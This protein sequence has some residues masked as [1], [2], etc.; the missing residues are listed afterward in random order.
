MNRHFE[1]NLLV[2]LLKNKRSSFAPLCYQWGLVA[3]TRVDFSSKCIMFSCFAEIN[4]QRGNA[5]ASVMQMLQLQDV[6]SRKFHSHS[7]ILEI[8]VQCMETA[9]NSHSMRKMYV[10][11][12]KK[13]NY[14]KGV[15]VI[16]LSF[17]INFR[18]KSCLI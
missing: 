5:D 1:N 18:R 6:T 9:F 2:H 17:S 8:R 15:L 12:Y 3:C 14:K 16:H 7:P 11:D 13:R 10:K 4:C